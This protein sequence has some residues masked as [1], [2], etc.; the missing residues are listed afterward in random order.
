MEQMGGMGGAGMPG[1][2]DL[3]GLDGDDEGED[4]AEAKAGEPEVS[5]SVESIKTRG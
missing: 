2:P 3:S 1:M 5:S 4:V